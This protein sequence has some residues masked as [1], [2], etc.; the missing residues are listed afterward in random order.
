LPPTVFFLDELVVS[1]TAP[2]FR[3]QDLLKKLEEISIEVVHPFAGE[4]FE[5]SDAVKM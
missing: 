4:F 1:G 2:E 5:A 3:R